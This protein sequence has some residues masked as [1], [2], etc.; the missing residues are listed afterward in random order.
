ML[1][2]TERPGLDEQYLVATNT[3]DLTLNPDRV[4]AATHLIAAGLLGNRMGEALIHLRAEWDAADKPRKMTEAEIAAR[5]VELPRRH[6]KPDV[7]RARTEA[8]VGYA[9]GMRNRARQM[10]G[11][12]PAMLLMRE[13]ADARQVDLDLLSPALYHFLNPTCPVCDG[14]GLRKVPDAPALSAKQCH[15]CNGSGVWPRPLGAERI[16]DW[17]RGCVGRA[18]QD[19][20]KL[21]RGEN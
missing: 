12:L 17:L 18:K 10:R 11:W 5:A 2:A 21:L 9:A 6:G 4:C 13:W 15:H 3:S 14:H 19:R 1:M 8:L 16:H 7:K 20:R